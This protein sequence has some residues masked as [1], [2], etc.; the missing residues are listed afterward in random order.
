[1]SWHFGSLRSNWFT[2]KDVE[3]FSAWFTSKVRFGEM[4]KLE[5]SGNRVRITSAGLVYA[6]PEHQYDYD[7]DESEPDD[8]DREEGEWDLQEFAEAIRGHR[9]HPQEIRIVSTCIDN[10]SKPC[11]S[12]L[13]IPIAG[14]PIFLQLTADDDML[15]QIKEQAA[16]I[17]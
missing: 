4:D 11:G 8:D 9:P 1:M 2:V 12:V 15:T 6:H 17:T 3:E 14:R 13:I 16:R 10:R 7:L 5:T